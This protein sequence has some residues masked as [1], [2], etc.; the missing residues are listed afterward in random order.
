MWS[1]L[2]VFTYKLMYSTILES[3]VVITHLCFL[4]WQFFRNSQVLGPIS[5]CC[6]CLFSTGIGSLK[7]D[8][9]LTEWTLQI[10]FHCLIKSWI[11]GWEM[12]THI[13]GHCSYPWCWILWPF[14]KL[15]K[16]RTILCSWLYS[17]YLCP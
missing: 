12:V 2:Q 9:L 13:P 7:L 10:Q 8:A 4:Q 14:A 17:P 6:I 3:L 1:D 11:T 15:C 16:T 5:K